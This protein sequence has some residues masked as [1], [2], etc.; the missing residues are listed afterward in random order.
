VYIAAEMEAR[1]KRRGLWQRENPMPP[2]DYRKAG[3]RSFYRVPQKDLVQKY[4]AH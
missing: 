4:G 1:E 2:W 3:T